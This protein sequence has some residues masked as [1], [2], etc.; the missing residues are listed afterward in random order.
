MAVIR[1]TPG[2]D[3]KLA[4]VAVE[5]EP[6]DLVELQSGSSTV[7][8]SVALEVLSILGLDSFSV[9]G[10][11]LMIPIGMGSGTPTRVVPNPDPKLPPPPPEDGA[12]KF[13]PSRG[14]GSSIKLVIETSTTK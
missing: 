4:P 12:I 3:G 8:S 5:F 2:A 13:H 11:S 7:A 6:G 9:N 14:T 10:D 1:C